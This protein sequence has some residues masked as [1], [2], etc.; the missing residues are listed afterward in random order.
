MFIY[1]SHVNHFKGNPMVARLQE[2]LFSNMF[3]YP[4]LVNFS[5][6]L[7]LVN[8]AV[9]LVMVHTCTECVQF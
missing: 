2:M 4:E 8:F 7:I 3:S 1:M 6:K 5:L 9:M